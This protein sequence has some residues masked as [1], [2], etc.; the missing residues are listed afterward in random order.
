MSLYLLEELSVSSQPL[1]TALGVSRVFKL[2]VKSV[3]FYF[4]VGMGEIRG[5]AKSAFGVDLVDHSRLQSMPIED[6]LNASHSLPGNDFIDEPD[7]ISYLKR[8]LT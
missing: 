2:T 8:L 4:C 1:G 6:L 5:P 3:A 7:T